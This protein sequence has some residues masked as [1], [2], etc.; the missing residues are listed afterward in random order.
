M[1]PFLLTRLRLKMTWHRVWPPT[2]VRGI[3]FVAF[4][5]AGGLFGVGDFLFFRRIFGNLLAN[6]VGEGIPRMLLLAV[7]GKLMGLVLLTTFTLLLFSAAVSA[8]SYLYLD[9][10]LSFLLPLP[11][12]RRRLRAQ[13]AA[14]AA[15]NAGYMVALLMIPVAVAYWSLSA[16]GI[17][18]LLLS[19]AALGVYLTIPLSLGI[20]F[21]VLMARFFPARRL[22]QVLTVMSVVMLS[23]LVVLFRMARPEALL[24]PQSSAEVL[25]VL[26]SIR[27]PSESLLPSTWLAEVVVRSAEGEWAK[28]WPEVAR[29]GGVAFTCVGFAAALLKVFHWRGYGRAQEQQSMVSGGARARLGDIA[30]RLILAPV[31]AG[32][33][34]RAILKRDALLFFRDPTQWGQL[35]ILAALVVIYLFNVRYMPSGVAVFRVAVSFWNLATLGLIVTSVASRFAFTAVG[36]EGKAYF[37]SRVLPVDVWSYLWAKYLFTAVP[38]SGLAALTLYGSNRFLGVEGKALYYSVFLAVASS[39]ALSA[40]A[41]C[42]GSA[43]PVFD[44][45]NPAKAVMSAWGLAYMFISLLYVGAVLILSAR[46]VYQYYSHLLGR[47]PEAAYAL[48]AMNVG[49]M[50][51]V[52]VL[53]CLLLAAWRLKRLEAT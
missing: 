7:A 53:G 14:E 8:L 35:I 43:Q 26:R 5:V 17:W 39:L 11:I 16:A 28:V 9:E 13:R 30:L 24:N 41:L 15:V 22:H 23:M 34:A 1:I 33:K 20:S 12:A 31:P 25:E 3:F 42:M 4:A 18:A 21:T 19:L 36:S 38:L 10:D 48:P 37:A 6:Q 46:P 47:G 51:A 52:M 27:M 29:L 32:P 40:L 49:G 45:R 50:S 44:S 2:L